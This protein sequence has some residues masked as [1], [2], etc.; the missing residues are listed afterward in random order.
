MG[1]V[2]H[3]QANLLLKLYD[4][5]REAKLREARS[6]FMAEFHASSAEELL[7]KY[8][9]N[10]T[11]NAQM[12][13][14]TGYWEMA[15]GMVNRGLIDDEMFFESGAEFWFIF[16]KIRPI[17]PGL[18]AMFGNPN[19]F[20]QME[21]AAGR[22]EQHWSRVAPGMAEFQRKRMAQMREQAAK[23]AH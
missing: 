21:A 5:R 4:L 3:D 8:P 11:M 19:A 6:W 2:S 18:R 9:P 22:L 12:R 13:M 14:V 23:A 1:Q 17:V 7:Q 10:T 16:E 15:C 20:K